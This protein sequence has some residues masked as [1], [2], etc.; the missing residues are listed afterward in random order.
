M[1]GK[2]LRCRE[3]MQ[4][5]KKFPKSR[6]STLLFISVHPETPHRHSEPFGKTCRRGVRLRLT[7]SPQVES[8]RIN[9]AKNL[10]GH[11]TYEIIRRPAA[12]GT[13][14]NDIK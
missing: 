10:C 6:L 2:P 9:S 5:K 11:N 14:Q 3:E 12:S 13:P 4:I 1:T 7:R 8:L